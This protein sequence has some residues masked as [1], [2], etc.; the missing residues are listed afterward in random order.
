V[1]M[2]STTGPLFCT[3]LPTIGPEMHG[4]VSLI[5]CRK[6]YPQFKT[7]SLQSLRL[8]PTC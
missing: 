2:D 5:S 8:V 1:H 3:K 4:N 6:Q 7:S